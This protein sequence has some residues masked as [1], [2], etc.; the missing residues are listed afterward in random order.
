MEKQ[1]PI[2]EKFDNSDGRQVHDER[3]REIPDPTPIAPPVGY[4]KQPSLHEQVREALLAEKLR[5]AYEEGKMETF[6]EADDFDVGDDFDPTSPYE[7][8]FDPMSAADKAAL[9]SH[10]RDVDAIL[11]PIPKPKKTPAAPVQGAAPVSDPA[12]P[13]GSAEP[14]GST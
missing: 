2:Y 4:R 8:D 14:S 6:E 12:K 11:G 1:A 10:G 5:M 9:S 7:A 13:G 3:G